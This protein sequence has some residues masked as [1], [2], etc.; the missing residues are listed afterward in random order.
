MSGKIGWSMSEV[1]GVSVVNTKAVNRASI[2]IEKP[3]M[4][5]S[6]ALP[7][8][9]GVLLESE[10]VREMLGGRPGVVINVN[11]EGPN[12]I[13]RDVKRW[14]VF[15]LRQD[16]FDLGDVQKLDGTDLSTQVMGMVHIYSSEGPKPSEI[17]NDSFWAIYLRDLWEAWT[18]YLV[19][20]S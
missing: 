11:A 3:F 8:R 1:V 9:P 7:G 18:S 19:M 6:R 13:T 16:D 20:S 10:W 14:K 4:L 5:L 2:T 17:R 15:Q 12:R